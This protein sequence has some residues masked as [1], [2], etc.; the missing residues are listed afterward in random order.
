MD[1]ERN[2][3]KSPAIIDPSSDVNY[4]E[5]AR[6]CKL[7][8]FPEFVTTEKLGHAM[9]PD[10]KQ[11]GVCADPRTS[12]FFCHSPAAT[13]L[14]SL[15]FVEKSAEIHPK[16]RQYIQQRLERFVDYF[17]IRPHYEAIQKRAAELN[18]EAELS[19]ED[20]GYVW[21]DRESGIK[22]R[23]LRLKSAAEVKAAAEWLQSNS[24]LL[25]FHDRNIV[26]SKVLEKAA[27]YGA[28]IGE[29]LTEYLERQA[30]RGV[31]EPKEVVAMIR[32]RATL[33]KNA[34]HRM[35][36][37]KLAD[38]VSGKPR[39]TLQPDQLVKLAVTMDQID[40]AIGLAGKYTSTI[41]APE[42]VIFSVTFTK[43]AAAYAELCSLTSGTV[44]SKDQFEKLSRTDVSE[45]FGDD[46]AQS[47]STGLSVDGEKM[48]ELASTLPRPE[49]ELL[50]QLMSSRDMNPHMSKAASVP[51]GFSN[52]ELE[53]I[54]AAY[55]TPAVV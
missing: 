19:D 13:W 48:A 14:S 36:I 22:S 20:F 6:F 5:L 31:C 21:V 17:Q 42:D 27:H 7:Y 12:Q 2:D 24:R 25:P 8:D 29:H 46:F 11:P 45:L 28:A 47:V 50:D 43:A 41:R 26:A 3:M 33:C 34:G 37:N 38:M 35:E 52:E 40:N 54:A 32:Q 23:H 16:D 44:Y 51:H 1:P 30:G 49:A 15:Y 55:E 53:A 9:N 39:V 10:V 18:K 4:V